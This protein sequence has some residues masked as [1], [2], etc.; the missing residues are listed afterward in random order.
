[1]DFTFSTCSNND[2]NSSVAFVE[3]GD[4]D[5]E[6]IYMNEGNYDDNSIDSDTAE[7]AN[8]IISKI[9]GRMSFKKLNLLHEA[10]QNNKRPLNQ[11]L[12]QYYDTCMQSITKSKN[13]E[14]ILKSGELFPCFD[15]N[16]LK[17]QVMYVAGPSGSGKSYY[18]AKL[19]KTYHKQFPDNNII[20]FSNKLEDPVFDRLAYINRIV[21]D[22][23]LLEDKMTLNELKDSLIIFDDIEC[24]ILKDINTELDRIRDLILLQGRSYKTSFIYISH[25]LTNYKQ[26]RNILNEAHQIT[27]FPRLTTKYNLKY[28]L[29]KY[30]GFD[31]AEI[32]KVCNLPSRWITINKAPSFV[33]YQRGIY[34][35][36]C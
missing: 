29:E 2:K 35:T 15:E 18:S 9:K 27:L 16:N 28:L 14:I 4:Y 7:I 10:I 6:I 3:G 5:K 23:S 13:K 22:N 34:L 11:E 12:A 33:M 20:L 36:N 25:Q 21:I 31:K 17:R 19:C 26:T 24:S 30:F 32:T 8:N 1:M